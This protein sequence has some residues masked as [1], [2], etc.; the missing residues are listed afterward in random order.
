MVSRFGFSGF[1]YL[2]KR[3]QRFPFVEAV[4]VKVEVVIIGGLFHIGRKF[5]AGE[6]MCQERR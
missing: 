3:R 6:M 1:F 4:K 2:V 5:T